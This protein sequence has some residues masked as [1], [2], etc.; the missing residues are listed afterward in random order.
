MDM[1]APLALDLPPDIRANLRM[2]ARVA[3][4]SPS[5]L[6]VRI[7][8]E[9]LGDPLR[10]EPE[11]TPVRAEERSLLLAPL[12]A[13]LATDLARAT[14][15]GDLQR[16]L[17]GHGYTFRERG[18][19]LALYCTRTAARICTATELGWSCCD[20][21]RRFGAPFPG[22][23]HTWLEPRALRHGSAIDRFRPDLFADPGETLEED[24]D[25]IILIEPC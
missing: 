11:R 16:R 23:A 13:L 3:G 18:G 19:G 8:S 6:A 1:T 14:G 25:D 20:L 17:A 21:M 5:A 22:H 15:W 9:T 12:R 2:R 4:M 24:D 10:D 7:L